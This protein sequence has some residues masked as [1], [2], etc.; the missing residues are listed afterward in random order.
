MISEAEGLEILRNWKRQ[1]TVVSFISFEFADRWISFEARIREVDH[2]L[3]VVEEPFSAEHRRSLD[4]EGAEFDKA[5]GVE[6]VP[7][8]VPLPGTMLAR[9]SR[10]LFVRLQDGRQLLFAEPTIV[11]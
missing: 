8:D 10:F 6:N 5:E 11:R 4:L 3:V 9:F 1:R 2:S 7:D